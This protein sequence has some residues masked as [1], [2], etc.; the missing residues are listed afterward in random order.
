MV[1]YKSAHSILIFNLS[2]WDTSMSI[3]EKALYF[4]TTFYFLCFI[5][6]QPDNGLG[7]MAFISRVDFWKIYS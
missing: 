5:L 7:N 1:S 6:P 3:E 2:E 4:L